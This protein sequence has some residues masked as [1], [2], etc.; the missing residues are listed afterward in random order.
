MINKIEAWR[1]YK[2]LICNHK[3]IQ[4]K[5]N[6][7]PPQCPGCN[8]K[9]YDKGENIP[10][11]ICKH[12]TMIPQIHHAN[13]IR[14]DNNSIN[15]VALCRHCHK[16]IHKGFKN[17]KPTPVKFKTRMKQY[18]NKPEILYKLNEYSLLLQARVK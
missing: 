7:I 10:C 8:G 9:A 1:K 15:R 17:G 3:W 13:G 4:R 12:I 18:I 5:K 14:K 11:E 16:E 6:T 2:C